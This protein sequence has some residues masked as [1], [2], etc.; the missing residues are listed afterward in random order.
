VETLTD[1][2]IR[3][4]AGVA[5]TR[6]PSASDNL[7]QAFSAGPARAL[8]ERIRRQLDPRGVLGG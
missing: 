3:P 5:Y 6:H 1:A 8:V 2:V 4:S 7:S